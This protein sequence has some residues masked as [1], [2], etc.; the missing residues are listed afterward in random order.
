ML[1]QQKLAQAIGR[2]SCDVCVELLDH[3]GTRGRPLRGLLDSGCSRTI[4]FRKFVKN[5][6]L[7]RLGPK[8]HVTYSTYGGT[9]VSKAAA[10]VGLRLVEFSNSKRINYECRVDEINSAEDSP[11]DVIIGADLMSDIG[12]DLHFS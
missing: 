1:K 12:I 11:Y 2:H 4:I 5:R 6:Q 7:K 10:P 8:D 3:T 9:V